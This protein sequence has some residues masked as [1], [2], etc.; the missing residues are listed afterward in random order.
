MLGKCF[1]GLNAFACIIVIFDNAHFERYFLLGFIE[2]KG[3][4]LKSIKV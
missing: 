2:F 1:G 3:I 4:A